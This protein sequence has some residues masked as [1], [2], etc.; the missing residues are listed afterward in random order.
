MNEEF[1]EDELTS[2]DPDGAN[3][4][5]HELLSDDESDDEF[6]EDDG[7]ETDF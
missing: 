7:P 6:R 4:S 5:D 2:L 1:R 3:P